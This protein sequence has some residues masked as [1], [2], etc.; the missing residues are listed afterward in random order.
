MN[1]KIVHIN[2]TIVRATTTISGNI[3]SWTTVLNTTQSAANINKSKTVNKKHNLIL[4]FHLTTTNRSITL[5]MKEPPNNMHCVDTH[6][7]RTDG[8]G[9]Y[10]PPLPLC[11][12][13]IKKIVPPSPSKS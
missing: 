5:S 1:I 4:T 8:H 7:N 9:G 6:K 10:T 12:R 3:I 13:G 2:Y 11:Y